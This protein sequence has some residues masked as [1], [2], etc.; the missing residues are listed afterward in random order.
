MRARVGVVGTGWWATRVHLPALAAHPDAEVVGVA[1]RDAGRARAAAAHFDVPRAFGS[2]R[3][4]LALA[5]DAVV[6]ATPHDAHFE[7]AR[8]CLAAGCDV[9]VEKPMVTRVGEG[10]EL[11]D[12]ARRSGRRLH[13]GYPHPYTTLAQSLRSAV[14]DGRLGRLHLATA[15]FA[16][17][18]RHLYPAAALPPE[19]PDALFPPS[20]STYNDPERG[21]GQAHTQVTHIA[22]LLFFV[23]GLQPRLAQAFV[24]RDGTR[25][26]VWDVAS[27]RAGETTLG[28]IA[29]TGAVPRGLPAVEEI[30]LFGDVG[31]A[32]YDLTAGTLETRGTDGATHRETLPGPERYPRMA[33]ARRLV[34]A[35]LGRAPV[36]VGGELG[37]LAVEFV[38]ALLESA[39]TGR[40]A[41]LPTP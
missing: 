33:P 35:A 13:V 21:G 3:E 37:L 14:R 1:D 32:R 18:V 41:S 29:S 7:V 4:L 27:F 34:D 8:D 2:H 9:L 16:T 12:L 5:P 26:D 19:A 17:S 40:P 39:R 24:E 28:T 6:V 20:P 25:V 38:A 36:L 23:S 30:L 22:A 15:T 11:V 10:R 31:H